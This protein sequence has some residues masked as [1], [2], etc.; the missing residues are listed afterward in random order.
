MYK[1][2]KK[3]KR[4]K[5]VIQITHRLANVVESD[6]IYMMDSG[7]IVERGT[8]KELM[9]RKGQYEKMYT[10]QKELELYTREEAM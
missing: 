10:A 8:H 3:L 6:E 5:T 9:E 1:R 2:Q 7:N 4:E